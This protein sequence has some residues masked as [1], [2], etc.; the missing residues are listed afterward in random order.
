[1]KTNINSL[2]LS[3]THKIACPFIRF[4]SFDSFFNKMKQGALSA[5]FFRK[6]YLLVLFD[7][8]YLHGIFRPLI[9]VGI[10]IIKT[11]TRNEN[12]NL[13]QNLIQTMQLSENKICRETINSLYFKMIYTLLLLEDYEIIYSRDMKHIILHNT[14]TQRV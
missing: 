10:K 8:I 3:R 6:V 9:F 13:L 7:Q 2:Y 12:I 11:P 14:N 1:M 4:A 5:L